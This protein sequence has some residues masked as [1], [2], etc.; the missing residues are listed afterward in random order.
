MPPR[1][2]S[3]FIGF[4]SWNHIKSLL[5]TTSAVHRTHQPEPSAITPRENDD[6][7]F[8][9]HFI[10]IISKCGTT[11]T[12]ATE[13][14]HSRLRTFIIHNNLEDIIP[15]CNENS[16]ETFKTYFLKYLVKDVYNRMPFL[17]DMFE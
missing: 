8:S 6:D 16:V 3:L 13:S 15:E 5:A 11:T 2:V 10:T 17:I 1:W 12:N 14:N 4:I 7:Q 9:E